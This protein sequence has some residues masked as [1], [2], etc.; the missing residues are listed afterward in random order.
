[1][2]G[3]NYIM[4]K[5]ITDNNF[6]NK[7][8]GVFIG[9]YNR[10]KTILTL[11]VVLFL[12]FLFLGIL[13]G[14]FSS[15]YI[16]HLLNIYVKLLHESHIQINTLSIFFHNLQAALVAYFGGLIGIIPVGVLSANGFIYGAFLGYLIHGPIVTSSGVFTPLHFIVYTLPHGI[17]ELP[18]FIIASAAGFRLTTMV[19]G[20]I[21]SIMRK[22][23]INDHYW[24]FKDSLI[25][26]AIA[27]L[28]IFIAAIIEANITLSLGNYITGL[29][30]TASG[31]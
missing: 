31:K 24:K 6:W 20:L 23:P 16:G 21:K 30:L 19:I 11:S 8:S 12:G 22:T 10:N 3:E 13:I 9:L 18:G 2:N 27:I 4:S 28:L 7:Y 15:D 1:M 29:N 5:Q 17:L 25:L 26:L 14:Y